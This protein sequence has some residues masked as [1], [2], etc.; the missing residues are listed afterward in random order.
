MPKPDSVYFFGTCLV[1]LLFPQAGL[2]AM[3]LLER[4][5]VQVIFPQ[6]QTCCGQPAYNSGYRDEARRVARV[7]LDA[8]RRT[9][10]WWCH[11]PPVPECSRSITRSCS[12]VPRTPPA[13][14]RW[15]PGWWS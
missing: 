5:G 1:D 2:C 14:W 12:P 13:P 10:R 8:L 7:Q 4:E 9:S 11:P 6:D 3:R 15:P